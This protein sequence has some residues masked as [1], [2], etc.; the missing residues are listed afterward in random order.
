VIS[1]RS[2]RLGSIRGSVRWRLLLER[3]MSDSSL[4]ADML[5][6]GINVS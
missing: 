1:D 2:I 6:V 3:G 4:R 5:G